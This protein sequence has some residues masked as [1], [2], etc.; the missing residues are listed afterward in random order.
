MDQVRTALDGDIRKKF[1]D[2]GY[3]LV[4]WGDPGPV[5]L[6]SNIPLKTRNDLLQMKLWGWVDDP[7]VRTLFQ[8]MGIAGMP[9]GVP[10]VLPSL[11][12]GLIN[13]CYGSPSSTLGFQW[14]S[15][16]KYISSLV[17]ITQSIGAIV[18]QK[19]VW[20]ALPPDVQKRHRGVG[21]GS[22]TSSR[23]QLRDENASG[24]EED[25]VARPP[26]RADA[27]AAGQRIHIPVEAGVG[28]ARRTA[29]FEGLPRGGRATAGR[30]AR[31]QVTRA[32]AEP[33]PAQRKRGWA[34][35]RPAISLSW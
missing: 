27:A 7:M 14:H 25:G 28:E 16:V 32:T 22:T 30:D 21:A 34:I 17:V 33:P 26:D 18:I 6:F 3:V 1:E 2:K 19:K 15:K 4:A 9:L 5:H 13:A 24:D 8:I 31:R 10:D 29:L 12:T 23:K 20:D 11:Q 35:F